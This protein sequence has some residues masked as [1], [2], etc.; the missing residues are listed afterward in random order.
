VEKEQAKPPPTEPITIVNGSGGEKK[1]QC[2]LKKKKDRGRK[3][4]FLQG[5]KVSIR[6]VRLAVEKPT[7]RM[8]ATL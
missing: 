3:S 6:F 5:E 2:Y 7:K 1:L 8:Q 4:G